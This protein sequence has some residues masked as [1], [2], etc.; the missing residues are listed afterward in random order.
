MGKRFPVIRPTATGW[1]AD[2]AILVDCE[3]KA[4]LKRNYRTQLGI[5][6]EIICLEKAGFGFNYKNHKDM[7]E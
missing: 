5:K 1:H 7:I 6:P 3:N 2:N 4:S